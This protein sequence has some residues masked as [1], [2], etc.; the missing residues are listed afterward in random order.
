M[1]KLKRLSLA[2]AAMMLLAKTVSPTAGRVRVAATLLFTML[3]TA[4]AWADD[5]NLTADG[6]T[7][8]DVTTWTECTVTVSGTSTITFINRISISGTVI[9][10]I[11]EGATLTA[12]K[13]IQVPNGATLTINESGTGILTAS[14]SDT[15]DYSAAIGGSKNVDAGTI[16]IKGGTVNANCTNG[17]AAAIGGGPDWDSSDA[18]DVGAGTIN[19]SGG[20][21]NATSNYTAAAIGGGGR[22]RPHHGYLLRRLG[23]TDHRR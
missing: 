13:G 21:V 8:D 22:Q 4:T 9:L 20:T 3:M 12:S 1:R 14:S 17:Y 19:I 5:V 16:N 23:C 7:V 6:S 11:G 2:R 18:N 10:N 15:N